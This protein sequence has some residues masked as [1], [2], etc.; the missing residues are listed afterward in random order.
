MINREIILKGYKIKYRLVRRRGL[1]NLSLSI[2]SDGILSATCPWYVSRKNVENFMA[3]KFDWIVEKTEQAKEFGANIRSFADSRAA[4]ALYRKQAERVITRKVHEFNKLYNFKFTKVVIR[5]QKTRWG[6]CSARGI[7]N[8]NYKLIFL[9]P[10]FIDYVVVHEL[11]HL[12]EM[13]HSSKFWNLVAKKF[14]NYKTIRH[15]LHQRGLELR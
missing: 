7:L 9:P 13:N 4:Y 2:N 8:F 12:K 15:D 10:R 1:K 6:S 11:C 14:P 5:H 3:E